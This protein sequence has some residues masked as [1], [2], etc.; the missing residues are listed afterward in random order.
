MSRP[1]AAT[2]SKRASSTGPRGATGAAAARWTDP[3]TRHTR[4]VHR[5]T[6]A[7]RLAEPALGPVGLEPGLDRSGR[8][9]RGPAVDPEEREAARE[10]DRQRQPRVGRE[11]ERA[12]E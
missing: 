3:G 4:P 7:E 1:C 10:R 12:A 2:S 8:A 6:E 5:S 11:G 9:R